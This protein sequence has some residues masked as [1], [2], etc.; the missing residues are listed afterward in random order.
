MKIKYWI[1]LV[2]L[3][4][5]AGL[6]IMIVNNNAQN[7]AL[8]NQQTTTTT[9]KFVNSAIIADGAVSAQSQATLNFQTSGKLIRLP[10]KEGDK[11][12]S[13]QVI[14]QLDNYALQKQLTVALNNY[15]ITRD[16][17]DQTQQNAGNQL[18][19]QQL[20]PT[21]SKAVAN[22]D[23]TINDALERILDQTQMT[24]NNSV[25]SVDLA[26][27]ALQLSKLVSPIS[28]IVAHQDVNVAGVNITPATTFVVADP[29]SA[30]F[31]AKVAQTNIYYVHEGNE[32]TILIDGLQDKL[33]GTVEKIYPL[34]TTLPT[35]QVVYQV[36]IRCD[37]LVEKNIKLDQI[38]KAIIQTNAEKVALIPAWTVINGN[39]VWVNENN[40]P[41]LKQIKVG[42]I[43][44]S[45][46]E[47][48]D[49]LNE[50]DKLITDPKLIAS[51]KYS[52]L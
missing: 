39:R 9:V 7:S 34:K 12:R 21:Y 41:V 23:E 44:D 6:G 32:A 48:T 17:F 20:A 49:G 26:N 30:V 13:G 36:D 46:I 28:G 31:R 2:L 18:L 35:G 50:G 45:E 52:I 40:I 43:H 51:L 24:L 37:D 38:G 8:S 14:A 15:K 29:A 11:I 27:Y 1:L 16:N 4:M 47:V 25:A 42:K 3:I 10:F 5:T 22:V 33:S 19:K